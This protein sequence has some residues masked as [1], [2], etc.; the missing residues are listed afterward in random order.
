MR[1]RELGRTGLLVPPVCFGG[2]VLGWTADRKTSFQIL[3]RLVGA[4]LNFID[5]ADA[6]SAWV[7]GHIGGESESVLGDWIESRRN[8]EKIV[9]ATKVGAELGPGRKG[10]SRR[11]IMKA[12]E[13][14]LKRLKTDYIDIYQSHRDDPFTPV[15][16]TMEAYAR[17]IH[18]GKVRFIGASNF[19]V[20]RL[21]EAET[22]AVE[23]GWPRY[24]V[25]QPQY[26]LYDRTEFESQIAPYCVSHEVGAMCY[27]GLA[28]GFLTGK[29]ANI[30]DIQG[31]PRASVLAAYFNERGFRILDALKRVADHRAVSPAQVALSWVAA[32]PGVTATIA[33]VTSVS[34][35][36]ELI[37]AAGLS[38]SEQEIDVLIEAS[39][40]IIESRMQAFS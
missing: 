10:L 40:P 15:D 23:N 22:V 25:V 28:T 20:E 35:A 4:G 7:P 9:I 30:E 37:R 21:N 14:S 27:Y 29:Y 3:D 39:D 2:N 31:K 34:Q 6:Y 11:Y 16:E 19:D 12:V 13:A 36:D 5:T 17:L 1:I 33:S 24:E 18:Q 38:L 8:R 32:R 26:N